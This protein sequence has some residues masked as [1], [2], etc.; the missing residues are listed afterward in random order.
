[1]IYQINRENCFLDA[2]TQ[3]IIA[4]WVEKIQSHIRLMPEDLPKLSI[5]IKHHDKF[6][7]YSGWMDLKLPKKTL[8][9]EFSGKTIEPMLVDA[10]K[11]FMTEISKYEALHFRGNS[12]NPHHESLRVNL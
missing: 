8:R 10:F 2:H 11:K 3:K 1:M 5:D 7:Y 4:R 9:M 6:P 12:R